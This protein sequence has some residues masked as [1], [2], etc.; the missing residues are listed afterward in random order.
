[1]CI[2][3]WDRFKMV[4]N[5]WAWIVDL[6]TKCKSLLKIIK[7][8]LGRVYFVHVLFLKLFSHFGKHDRVVSKP[9]QFSYYFH[10]LLFGS[11]SII[12][13]CHKNFLLSIIIT[14]HKTENVLLIKFEILGPSCT[15]STADQ[16]TEWQ[17][18][19][20]CTST[21]WILR[22][23]SISIQPESLWCILRVYGMPQQIV[24]VIKG[25]NNILNAE[26]ETA[27]PALVW[28][29]WC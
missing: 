5:N 15:T 27:N 4:E 25:F 16:C 20:R 23:L 12:T 7:N 11:K 28:R 14:G 26:W 13:F 8:H 10:F 24:L 9:K 19:L 17:R 22:R 1:M 2:T 18:Q 6:F 3:V 29:P 21:M